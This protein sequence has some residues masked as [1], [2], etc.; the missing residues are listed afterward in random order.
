MTPTQLGRIVGLFGLLMA[1]VGLLVWSGALNWFGRLPGDVRI[2]RPGLRIQIPWV[3]LLVV[4]AVFNAL[5]W[6]VQRW[7]R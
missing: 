1:M 5:V 2:D 6:C 7:L 4:S 3:S